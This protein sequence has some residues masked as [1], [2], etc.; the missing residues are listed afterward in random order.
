MPR[1]ELHQVFNFF[2]NELTCSNSGSTVGDWAAG[3][4]PSSCVLHASPAKALETA[5]STRPAVEAFPAEG[6]APAPTPATSR[7]SPL[8]PSA[9]LLVLLLPVEVVGL[10]PPR[11][12]C[13]SSCCLG[14]PSSIGLDVFGRRGAWGGHQN[15]GPYCRLCGGRCRN[16]S[17]PRPASAATVCLQAVCK[18]RVILFSAQKFNR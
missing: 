10:L 14:T 3:F 4:A 5:S 8:F 12:D 17:Q 11:R 13:R 1:C 16:S 2:H 18:M 6:A 7:S 9:E 15:C